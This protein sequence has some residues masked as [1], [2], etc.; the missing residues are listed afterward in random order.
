MAVAARTRRRSQSKSGSSGP[1][2]NLNYSFSSGKPPG[3]VDVATTAG[4]GIPTIISGVCLRE[5][6][7]SGGSGGY[8]LHAVM[9]DSMAIT[10]T[11]SVTVTVGN[12][13]VSANNRAVGPGIF[14][15]DGSKGIYLRF[16][17]QSS[18]AQLITWDAGVSAAKTSSTQ[19]ANTGDTITLTGTLAGGVWTW[20]AKKNGGAD[21]AALTWVD[22]AH[23]ID[24]PGFKP[25]I[26]FR[27]QYSG[28]N[29]YS[30]G[31]SNITATAA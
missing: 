22:S 26:A 27:Q 28:S 4:A 5:G 29:F 11:I 23:E 30:R 12:L 19:V 8:N 20:T 10:T 15:S 3:M 1:I 7:K 6:S 18:T 31:V 16:A 2:A 14:S 24:L 13:D 21:I 17:S 25:G 9:P